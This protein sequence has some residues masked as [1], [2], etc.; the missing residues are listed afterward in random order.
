M[1]NA[2][3]DVARAFRAPCV[4]AREIFNY[5]Q[6][7]AK[8]QT[9][10]LAYHNRNVPRGIKNPLEY[11]YGFTY[12]ILGS[13]A[14]YAFPSASSATSPPACWNFQ[15]DLSKPN[16]D[17][18]NIR[19][20]VEF[21]TVSTVVEENKYV[22]VGR[23]F[24]NFTLLR[25]GP[26]TMYDSTTKLP[27]DEQTK[28]AT[29]KVPYITWFYENNGEVVQL[30]SPFTPMFFTS[31]TYD[32]YGKYK[33]LL[34]SPLVATT[35]ELI[36]KGN[37]VNFGFGL[38]FLS[39]TQVSYRVVDPLFK[40]GFFKCSWGSSDVDTRSIRLTG[41][42]TDIVPFIQLRASKTAPKAWTGNLYKV[43]ATENLDIPPVN[44]SITDSVFGSDY[45][46][47]YISEEA[48][49]DL[50]ADFGIFI[51]TNLDE[52]VNYTPPDDDKVNPDAPTDEIPNFPD[53]STETT[54]IEPAGITPATFG[55]ALV[56]NATT[57]RQFLDWVCNSTVDIGNWSRLFANPA[58][59]ITGIGLYNLDIVTRDTAHVAFSETTNILGVTGN[60]PNYSI[61]GGYNNIVDGGTLF[62][63]AY[64]GNYADFTNMTYQAFIP[65][66]GFTTLRA[67]DVVNKMLHL[68]YA[69]DFS[70]GSAV[71]F[72]NSD[73]KLIYTAPCTVAGKIPLS[74]SDR[75]SQAINNTLSAFSSIGG[76]LGGIASGNIGGGVGAAL[77]GLGNIQFQTNFAN[78]GTMSSTNIYRLLPAFI[79]R[80]RY[81]LFLPSEDAAYKGAKYQE[82][83]G[84]PSSR[85]DTLLN[86]VDNNG[87]IEC[88]EVYLHSA[89]ATD[90]EKAQIVALLKSGVYL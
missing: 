72:L 65:F 28:F 78:K 74:T 43:T 79:E 42:N 8:S 52:V 70:A 15:S 56:Y 86:A 5:Y 81:D 82:Y 48:C 36:A 4:K 41:V 77:S 50:F 61:L 35:E 25:G 62:L 60:I 33:T 57:L 75:N 89:T 49:I 18:K 10:H 22:F 27:I 47:A 46:P 67:C 87:F 83:F 3:R 54:P 84:A 64:Y 29:W 23:E 80:T 55:Q 59:V 73:D 24:Q 88:D 20:Y 66:V 68:Y 51:S 40:S 26:V 44:L 38:P 31:G 37:T 34:G 90:A 14:S 76:L 69:V 45:I 58:D 1:A 9:S 6:S 11:S 39:P 12:G 32:Y 17:V 53:N 85:F 19:G 2:L 30:N 63:Q 71:V 16:Y 13:I 7:V 21:K